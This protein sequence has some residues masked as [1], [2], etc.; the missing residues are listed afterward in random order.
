MKNA[1]M[2]IYNHKIKGDNLSLV[3]QHRYWPK[4]SR[5]KYWQDELHNNSDYTDS[6]LPPI[7]KSELNYLFDENLL[8]R[9]LPGLTQTKMSR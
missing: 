1:V 7:F 5:C 8:I 3:Q 4:T 9:C 6:R 2:A